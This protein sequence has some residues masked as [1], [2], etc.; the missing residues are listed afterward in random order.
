MRFIKCLREGDEIKAVPSD[1]NEGITNESD[2]PTSE[3][4]S[5]EEFELREK[6]KQEFLAQKI[7]TKILHLEASQISILQNNGIK[8]LADFLEQTES[9][10]SNMKV[11]KGMVFTA[12][13]L[14]EQE[15]LKSKLEE[16]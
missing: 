8:T 14:K 5:E 9:S 10:F 2:I 13:F 4:N 16:L 1:L 3:A 12:K 11:K 15:K 7:S 6:A